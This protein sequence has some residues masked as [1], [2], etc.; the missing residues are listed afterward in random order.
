M[1]E[2]T[3]SFPLEDITVRS[4]G[5]GRT[6][7]AYAAVFGQ[8]VPISDRDGDY[9]ERISPTAFDKTLAERGT[10]FGVLFNHGMTIYGT[11]SDAATM[12]IGTCVEARVDGHGLRTVTEYNRTQLAD[13]ALEAIKAGSL[14]AQSFAGRFV[15]SDKKGPFRAVRGQ[16]TTVTRQEIALREY[17]PTPFPAYDTAVITGVRADFGQLL[18]ELDALD[19]DLEP[20][21]AR[22]AVAEILGLH[23]D[24]IDDVLARL[25]SLTTRHASEP[26]GTTTPTR[27]AGADEPRTHS[28]RSMP[29]HIKNFTLPAQTTPRKVARK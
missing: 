21:A 2:F 16:R 6:V 18:T 24:E 3:R 11:P 7:E 8:D 25:S 13:D 4:G 28:G 19:A 22:A 10:N 20:D 29:E 1:N 9:I 27:G 17:G 5:T 23:P 14:R 12:P 26:A 15:Q